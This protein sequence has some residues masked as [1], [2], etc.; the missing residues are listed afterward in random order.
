LSTTFF[1]GLMPVE[2][3]KILQKGLKDFFVACFF[4]CLLDSR[5]I[6]GPRSESFLFHPAHMG[7][8]A[9]RQSFDFG[10]ACLIFYHPN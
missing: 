1:A 10:L 7:A 5:P 3:K 6:N 2:N 9:F 4:C 8:L